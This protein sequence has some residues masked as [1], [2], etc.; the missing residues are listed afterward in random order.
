MIFIL[1]K[2]GGHII[3]VVFVSV[4]KAHAIFLMLSQAYTWMFT[5]TF[6]ALYTKEEALLYLQIDRSLSFV[7]I[8]ETG[9]GNIVTH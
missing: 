5:H 7:L 8:P 2:D 6:S 4:Y 1:F 9:K 3:F